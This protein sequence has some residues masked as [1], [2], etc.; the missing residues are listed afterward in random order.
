VQASVFFGSDIANPDTVAKFWADMQHVRLHHGR[1]RPAP[2]HGPVRQLGSRVQGQPV[3]GPQLPALA[4]R[5]LRRAY[6]AAD[7][8]LDPVKRA[9]LYIRMND[10][11][12]GDNHLLPVVTRPKVAA[13]ATGW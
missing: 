10:L 5:R 7:G 9:A 11:V 12:C 4:Q 8:E 13:A 3:A 6:K 1:A 2:L